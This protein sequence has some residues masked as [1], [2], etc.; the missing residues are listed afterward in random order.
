MSREG[1]SLGSELGLPVLRFDLLSQ[2]GIRHGLV[3]RD[4]GRDIDEDGVYRRLADHGPTVVT[5]QTH[6]SRSAAVD[7]DFTDFFPRRV[8]VDGLTSGRPG[9]ILTIHTADCV[10]VFLAAPDGSAVGVL[11]CGW[12]GTAAGFLGRAVGEFA[13]RYRTEPSRLV[14]AIGPRICRG[15]Y[16][17]GPE[18]ASR[19]GH[20]AKSEAG[21]GRWLLD[22]GEENRRQALEAGLLDSNVHL[23]PLCT[24]CRPDLFHSYRREGEA[25]RGKMVAFIEAGH[26][27][28]RP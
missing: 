4:G 25:L 6:S 15:C 22:L 26:E 23:S 1:W 11:H 13:Q 27:E 7:A 21:G 2:M 16:P 14:A 3:V 9:A 18:V 19:F 5:E 17:V 12:R 24:K 8:E 28:D 20:A 10:P